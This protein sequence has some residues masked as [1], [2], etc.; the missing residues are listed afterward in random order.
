MLLP[1][2][3]QTHIKGLIVVLAMLAGQQLAD[4]C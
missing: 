2:Q 4:T 3:V 1:A